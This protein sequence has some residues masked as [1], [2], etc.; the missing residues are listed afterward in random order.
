MRYVQIYYRK[1]NSINPRFDH[2]E[3]SKLAY[4]VH[5]VPLN[6]TQD[7]SDCRSIEERVNEGDADI[8]DLE[9]FASIKDPDDQ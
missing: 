6:E 2:C 8:R 5:T 9:E 1:C 7:E 3:G 4:S